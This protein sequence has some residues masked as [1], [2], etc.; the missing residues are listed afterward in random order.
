M[1]TLETL[2]EDLRLDL[3]DASDVLWTDTILERHIKHAV[4]DFS[5]VI[6]VETKVTKATVSDSR[7]IDI[8]ALHPRVRFYAVEFP[9]DQWPKEYVQFA[10]FGDVLT[11]LMD[12][13][14]NGDNCY[15]YYGIPHLAP[16]DGDWAG[17]TGYSVGDYV[18]PV[19]QN[20]YRYEC[21][22]AGTSGAGEPTWPTTVGD[23]VVDATATWTCQL[24]SFSPTHDETILLG[25]GGYA[26]TEYAAETI[27]TANVGGK[28]VARGYQFEGSRRLSQFKRKL[29]E[30]SHNNRV[31]VRTLYTPARPN[32]SRFKVMG[33]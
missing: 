18:V 32:A 11:L 17:T 7:E 14:A 29:K 8:S 19:T 2:V 22:A 13:A 27:N 26:L 25:A 5:L 1:A 24:A 15:I 21:T 9:I 30:I 12:S 10:S 31:R 3:K 20:G 6:P 16:D 4:S 33:P 28:Q 23:T